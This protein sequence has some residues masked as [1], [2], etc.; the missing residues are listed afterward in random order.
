MFAK[1][2]TLTD[3]AVVRDVVNGVDVVHVFGDLD[4]ASASELENE[5]GNYAPP[6][7]VVVDLTECSF[8]DTTGI[9]VLLRGFKQLDSR[10]R[11]VVAPKGHVARV[12]KITRIADLVPIN[13]SIAQSLTA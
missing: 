13:D 2:I 3:L 9:T 10:L 4:I 5:L 1:R 8:I 6:A 11:L 7:T 12:L